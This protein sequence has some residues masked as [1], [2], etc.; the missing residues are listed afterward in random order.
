MLMIDCGAKSIAL[1]LFCLQQ[2]GGTHLLVAGK[3]RIH[4]PL[5]R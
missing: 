1:S 5:P 3:T 2:T 4:L